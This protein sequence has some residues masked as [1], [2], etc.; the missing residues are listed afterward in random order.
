MYETLERVLENNIKK[1]EDSSPFGDLLRRLNGIKNEYLALGAIGTAPF[2]VFYSTMNQLY[3]ERHGKP[4]PPLV[5]ILDEFTSVDSKIMSGS[6]N[7]EDVI[8][9][10]KLIETYPISIVL[11]CADYFPSLNSHIAVSYTHLDVYKR[12]A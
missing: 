8:S 5:L 12:Q 11:I 10:L 1:S 6:V 4:L 2:S 3:Q 7:K 9:A